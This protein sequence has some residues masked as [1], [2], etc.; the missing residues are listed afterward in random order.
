VRLAM[1]PCLGTRRD[2]L[3]PPHLGNPMPDTDNT[4]LLLR[5]NF[6]SARDTR[7]G[8]NR[9]KWRA[10]TQAGEPA[11]ASDTAF[12]SLSECIADARRHGFID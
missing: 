9:W 3:R 6:T 12:V 8:S 2:C 11:Q 4:R 5:W 10:Y 7:D 1:R